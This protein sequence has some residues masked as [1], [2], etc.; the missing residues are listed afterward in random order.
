MTSRKRASSAG[1][2]GLCA[3]R[4]SRRRS[5]PSTWASRISASR[6]GVSR[7]RSLK[8]LAAHASTRWIV[9]DSAGAAPLG[10]LVVEPAPGGAGFEPRGSLMGSGAELALG[11]RDEALH[12]AAHLLEAIRRGCLEA[13]HDH[14]A[15]VRGSHQPPGAVLVGDAH[16]VDGAEG[17]TTRFREGGVDLPHHVELQGRWEENTYE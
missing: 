6:R 5:T 12:L 4:M 15:R 16:A 9:Q 17:A 7:P 11:L 10:A 14:G 8:S 13:Q 1:S 3:S 2:R